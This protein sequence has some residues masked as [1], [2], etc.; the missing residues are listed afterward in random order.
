MATTTLYSELGHVGTLVDGFLARNVDPAE[1]FATIHGGA[2]T[3]ALPDDDTGWVGIIAGGTS[4]LYSYL[5]SA[6]GSFN[7]STLSGQ[8]ITAATF[9]VIGSSTGDKAQDLGSPAVHV[10]GQTL[11]N[12]NNLVNGDYANRGT[13]SFGSVAWASLKQDDTY[14]DWTLNAAGLV[15]LN[16]AIGGTVALSLQVAWDVLNDT[17]GLTWSSGGI[18][19][20]YLQTADAG[21]SRR[22]KLVLT[23]EAASQGLEVNV[24]ESTIVNEV[25]G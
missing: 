11:A 21:E 10:A 16:N 4:D 17:T 2:G 8:T 13:T 12:A 9:S 25:T 18:T 1:T 6:A 22:M 5:R 19:R 20:W 14:V 15:Y 3:V 23:H 7:L 24:F